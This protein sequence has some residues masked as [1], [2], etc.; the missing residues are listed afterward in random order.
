MSVWFAML[1]PVVFAIALMVFFH[2]RIAWWE[3]IIPFVFSAIFIFT[4]KSV[5][6]YSLVYDTE[7]WTGYVTRAN[8]YESYTTRH[9]HTSTDSKG[10]TT[11][12][13]YYIY[14]P[15]EWTVEDNNG[16][17][18]S[19]DSRQYNS[20]KYQWKM[21]TFKPL[22]HFNQS[23]SGDGNMYFTD[24]NGQESTARI[25]SS[26]HSYSNRVQGCRN[27]FDFQPVSKEQVA[28]Y[29]LY[30]YPYDK[31][32]LA[33]PAVLGQIDVSTQWDWRWMNARLGKTKQIR[34]WVLLF[35]NQP[36]LAGQLQEAYWLRGNKNDL[37]ICLGLQ[38][39]NVSWCHTFSWCD[40]DKVGS[41]HE[42]I[43]DHFITAKT[44]D[45]KRATSFVENTIQNK[46]HRKNFDDFNYL[47]LTVPPWG[48]W[49]AYLG[50]FFI[51]CL[52][53]V[54][55]VLNEATSTE[56]DPKLAFQFE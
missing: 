34:T 51:N 10:H 27:V 12:Y 29:H 1:I 30:N 49:L 16:V 17:V 55:A 38:G 7:F 20:M 52:V 9:T 14:H 45:W 23:S 18:A 37:V 13:T 33:C 19:I 47:T 56:P 25:L 3:I 32:P 43:E 28:Q 21:E 44:L 22:F 35:P 4:A 26:Q 36:V 31:E 8:Y 40:R 54:W 15:A 24:W 53:S 41:L 39:N 11:T 5:A 50:T 48:Q 2:H 42:D 46:W 6:L